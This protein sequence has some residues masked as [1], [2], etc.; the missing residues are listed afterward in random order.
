AWGGSRPCT[1]Y[2]EEMMARRPRMLQRAMRALGMALALGVVVVVGL[3]STA[4]AATDQAANTVRAVGGAPGYGP[5]SGLRLNANF[6]GIAA[7][8]SGGG[9]WAVAAD[10]GVFARGDARFYGSTGGRKLNK[11][12]VGMAGAPAGGG[13]W[14]LCSPRGGLPLWPPRLFRPP[15]DT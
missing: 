4:N 1:Q 12:V 13:F 15:F 11:P 10:G 6:V 3:V 14:A 2:E 9:Y 8:E 5:D 7:L